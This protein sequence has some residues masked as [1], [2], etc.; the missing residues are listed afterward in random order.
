VQEAVQAA[1]IRD[2]ERAQADD[3]GVP[4]HS[5]LPHMKNGVKKTRCHGLSSLSLTRLAPPRASGGVG[6]RLS[7]GVRSTRGRDGQMLKSC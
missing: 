7:M 1:V 6:R 5:H 4:P 2:V 3:V